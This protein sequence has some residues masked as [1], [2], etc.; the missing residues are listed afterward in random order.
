M[1]TYNKAQLVNKGKIRRIVIEYEEPNTPLVV[2][3]GEEANEFLLD[4]KRS[5]PVK[6]KQ[7]ILKEINLKQEYDVLHNLNS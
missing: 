2:F 5:L 7:E 3:D 1:T 6:D 4:W